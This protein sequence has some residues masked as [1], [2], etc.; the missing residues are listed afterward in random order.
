MY[1]G[2][3]FASCLSSEEQVVCASVL[4]AALARVPPCCSLWCTLP[5]TCYLRRTPCCASWPPC[6]SH[7]T[8]CTPS[9]SAQQAG[10]QAQVGLQ[11]HDT[12]ALGLIEQRQQPKSA[13]VC[14][15]VWGRRKPSIPLHSCTVSLRYAWFTAALT[16]ELLCW[17]GLLLMF[18]ATRFCRQAQPAGQPA[19]HRAAVPQ[20]CNDAL[21]AQAKQVTLACNVIAAQTLVEAAGTATEPV[22][23]TP[24]V[25][26]LLHGCVVH[27]CPCSKHAH[28]HVVVA[29]L[30]VSTTWPCPRCCP[31]CLLLPPAAGGLL[32]TCCTTWRSASTCGQQ[33]HSRHLSSVKR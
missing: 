30:G 14:M 16:H 18:S 4:L 33:H 28:P 7:G 11:H 26:E 24:A 10:P 15:H 25:S 8:T 32:H 1:V 19:D 2:A 27:V 5:L 29:A 13:G 21:L 17:R 6:T 12:V 20:G 22:N 3:V 23:A 31:P 9:V